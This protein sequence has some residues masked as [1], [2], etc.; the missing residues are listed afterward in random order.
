MEM[1]RYILRRF[2]LA[3]LCL[4]I[5]VTIT[6]VLMIAVPG[7]PF[8]TAKTT[9]QVKKQLE[10]KYGLDLPIWDRYVK[11]LNN[12]IHLDLGV[13]LRERGRS[14]NSIIEE[15]FPVSLV[16]GIEA[17]TFAVS[18]GLTLG[19]IASIYR[20]RAL[21]YAA[22][23][24]AILG[25]S[26][27]NF[28]VASGLQYLLGFKLNLL[29]IARWDGP[30][31]T[32]LPAFSLGLGTLATMTRMMRSSMLE[33]INQDYVR[34]AKAKGL[35]GTQV[36]WR[37]CVRNAILPI[38][39]ILG[40]L[41]ANI[42]TGTLVVERI[43][44]IPGLG[45]YFVESIYNRDYPVIMGTTIFYAAMLLSMTLLVD[46]AYGLIDPRIRLAKGKGD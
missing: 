25:V 41:T 2:G 17:L 46:I 43:F 4:W 8:L 45:R 42:T 28:L 39:T 5:I 23:I 44:G 19:I 1:G 27:P 16:L 18:I 22:I 3:V 29:P 21:D 20:G 32:I 26:I 12:L 14:V 35:T 36:T 6:F 24:I 7:S 31:H 38:V 9:P 30:M 15:T 33:V 11:L 37:H 34:T 10:R 13:S 40:P